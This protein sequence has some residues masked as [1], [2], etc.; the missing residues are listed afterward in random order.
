[1]DN[2][3]LLSFALENGILDPTQVQQMKDMKERKI[4]L[5]NHPYK[6][7]Q[8]NKG[9]WYTYVSFKDGT[10][11]QLSR[12]HKE[13]LEDDI[14][15]FYKQEEENPTISDIFTLWNTRRKDLKQIAY[16]T[17]SRNVYVFNK[18]F[19]QFGKKRIRKVRPLDFVEFLEEQIAE[20][21]M[22]RKA[23][24]NL[25]CIVTGILK[26]AR[27]RE[28][29]EYTY[30]DVYGMLDLGKNCFKKVIYSDEDQVFNEKETSCIMSY[31]S[32][33]TGIIDYGLLLLFV[34]GMRIGEL[35]ALRHVDVREDSI[36]VHATE[37][38]YTDENGN[39]ISTIKESPKTDKGVRCII[40]P[41]GYL[42]L[43]KKIR[44]HNPFKEFAFT[45]SSGTRIRSLAF[46]RRLERVCEEL[47]IPYRSPHKIR[48][49]FGSILLDNNVDQK[50]IRD[51]MGHVDLSTT[52]SFYHY[53]RRTFDERQ[54]MLSSIKEFQAI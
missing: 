48:K 23:F 24:A 53:N 15:H 28:L 2:N 25:K 26:Y 45:Y 11:K 10:R 33:Q 19:K 32:S 35:A 9:Y 39:F 18:H 12:R 7:W 42:W 41:T 37:S 40:V 16:P 21:E 31:L 14:V 38:S 47:H 52:E 17:F 6:I 8:S 43:L 30:N 27:R 4:Y 5:E 34:T 29:I 54:K 44:L 22:T 46:R 50:T 51:T 49:T 20:Y 3:E 1:M 13:D 36:F